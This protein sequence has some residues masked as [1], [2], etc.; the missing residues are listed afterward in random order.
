MSLFLWAEAALAGATFVIHVVAGGKAALGL[1]LLQR[2]GDPILS[3]AAQSAFAK[4]RATS[5][6]PDTL[7]NTPLYA[8]A[9]GRHAHLHMMSVLRMAIRNASIMT[10]DY[11]ALSGEQTLRRVKPLALLFFPT[12]HLLA[13]YCMLRQD[14]R[15]FR[16]DRIASCIDTGESFAQEKSRLIRDYQAHIAAEAKLCENQTDC[17]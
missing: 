15:N 5:K 13:T 10:L 4:I 14:F 6:I 1:R 2:E 12:A 7:D 3:G 8:P 11:E 9:F 16:I 17:G